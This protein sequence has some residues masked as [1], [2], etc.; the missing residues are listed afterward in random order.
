MELFSI[1]CP[2]C[3]ARL[4]V[5]DASAIGQILNCPK[6]ASMVQVAAPDGWQPPAADATQPPAASPPPTASPSDR[7]RWEN[8]VRPG[9]KVSGTA[10]ASGSSGGWRMDSSSGVGSS[11][12]VSSSGNLATPAD[13]DV[14]AEPGQRAAAAMFFAGKFKWAVL[15]GVT[16]TAASVIAAV[17]FNRSTP[18]PIQPSPSIADS[19]LPAASQEATPKPAAPPAEQKPPK[20]EPAHLSR[21]WLPSDAQA[22][23]SLRP[24]LLW[25]RPAALLL[26]ERTGAFW[27]PSVGKLAAALG[28]D[29][30]SLERVTWSS[31]SVADVGEADW[32][33]GAVL[34]IELAAPPGDDLRGI[35]DSEP[36]DWAVA[37][38]PARL[39]KSHAWPQPFALVDK[40]LL[41]TGP[42]DQL[43]AL[44]AREEHRLANSA[45]AEIVGLLDADRPAVA[46]VDVRALHE[47][48][49][50]PHWLPLVEMLHAD[51]DDW[52]L[53][54]TM[55]LALGLTAAMKDAAKL[56][57]D[58]A[59]D[60]N[61]GAE[62]LQEALDRVLKAVET[63]IGGEGDML[64]D[65]LLAGQINTASAQELKQFLSAGQPALAGRVL[66]IRDSIV[67]ARLSF[68][69]DLPTLAS[70]FLAGIP[71]LE[72]GRLATARRLDEEHQQL[73]LK[74]L[75][76]YAK[77]EGSLPAGAVGANLLPPET[78]LSWQA[79]LL[80][81]FGHLDWHGELS[82]ARAWND[83]V[84]ARI[85]KRPLELLVN[86]ALGPT[87][88]KA[89]FPITHY[90]GMAGLGRDAGQLEANDPRAGVFGYRA[91]FSPTQ[92]P[93][94]ASHTIAL[95]GVS[96]RLGPWARG[97]EATVR[98]L[99]QRPYINGPDG[100]GSG[101]PDGMLVAMADGSVRFL[102]ANT[103]PGVLERLVT[104]AGGDGGPEPVAKTD[105]PAAKMPE[106][107][108]AAPAPAKPPRKPA[109]ID[110][111]ARLNDRLPEIELTT[112]LSELVDLLSQIST[113][114]ITLD[115]NRLAAAGVQPDASV[116]LKMTD[117]TIADILDE[118]L[119][120]FE[121]KYVEVGDQLVVID[122]N[123]PSEELVTAALRVGDLLKSEGDAERLAGL[124]ESFV[125]PASWQTAGGGGS[126]EIVGQTLTIEQTPAV[127]RQVMEFLGLL[128]RARESAPARDK[129]PAASGTRWSLLR[130]KLATP[131][132]ANFAEPAQ[133]KEIAAHLQ[134]VVGVEILFDG[135]AVAE[136]GASPLSRVEFAANK[137]PLGE[138]LDNLLEPLGLAYRCLHGKRIEITSVQQAAQDLEVEFYSIKPLLAETQPDELAASIRREVSPRAWRE[139]GGPSALALDG[140][141]SYLIVLAPQSVQIQLE[142]WLEKTP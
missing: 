26:F 15:G 108:A 49:I 77:T 141:S 87:S 78:R 23:V 42:E 122:A 89:G 60:G 10:P 36:L 103:D 125:N 38:A 52:Q 124:V 133:L 76:G 61:S 130:D 63:T 112:T 18:Q 1:V 72:A 46:A 2:T 74:A 126:L 93:D 50:L 118:A 20:Q 17:W 106:P 55:P 35:H 8:E 32:L 65:I 14:A 110:L 107:P 85:A 91:R 19:A 59:C 132:T 48:E 95:A 116:T 6:C 57:L 44:A 16:L 11:G 75:E 97:G 99:T 129:R 119:R 131:V 139:V 120:P 104:V 51:A 34:T 45:L 54:R 84:N 123:Q 127:K 4:K 30:K 81:Y 64:T 58:L 140:P 67:W 86:P 27:Q 37:G 33:S 115:L 13:N 56:E 71:Q 102:P 43:R 39:L 53:L 70:G 82:F 111:A 136:T 135:L 47:A 62:Q 142:R 109:G 92:I 134:K 22:V 128:R 24:K 80:P 137:E 138:A 121:L 79:T 98:G 21:R 7:R 114:P 94:G 12:D 83:P 96:Q 3:N 5:R 69:G 68:S 40:R 29:P 41:V 117:A 90:V 101:Q 9:E 66:G 28:L 73:L 88:T 100:F 105:K 31:T 25:A 113:I